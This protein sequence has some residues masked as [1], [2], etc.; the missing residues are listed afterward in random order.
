[1]SH[2]DLMSIPGNPTTRNLYEKYSPAVLLLIT[3]VV[4]MVGFQFVGAFL[5][6]AIAFPFYPGDLMSFTEAALNPVGHPEMRTPLLI[7]QG[8]GS[9]TG[10]ILMPWL[11]LK[12][13]YSG[14]FKDFVATKTDFSLI[15][16]AVFITL[17]F[18]GVNAPFIEW[19]QNIHFP[20]SLSGIEKMLRAMEDTLAQT[21]KFITEFDSIGQ[22]ILG[23]L[24]VAVI[25][26]I[27]EELVFRGLVQNHAYR[28]S[29]NIHVAIW[30][31]ALLFALFHL[32]FYG[33]VPRMFLGAL[34]GYLYFYSGSIIYPMVAHFFNNGFTLIML[35]LYNTGRVEYNIEEAEVIPWYQ[36]LLSA[37]LTFGLIYLF[38]KK[39]SNEQ[40]D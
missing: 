16:S 34:F 15:L 5:G 26:G 38:N 37:A 10:F 40:L 30:L 13:L 28:L 9:F 12:Y 19:N 36:V 20:E 6:I 4:T 17:F 3:L 8:V 21:S 25:P 7:M 35:Y 27:G 14:S 23:L 2:I 24:V 33:L 29:K 11:L 1:M 32:Q 39:A 22:L 31:S 18:M